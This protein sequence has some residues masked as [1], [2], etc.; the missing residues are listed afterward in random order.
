MH[1]GLLDVLPACSGKRQAIKYLM[2]QL[3]FDY[4]EVLFTADSSDDDYVMSSLIPSAL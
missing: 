4:L 1:I 3:G 2:L